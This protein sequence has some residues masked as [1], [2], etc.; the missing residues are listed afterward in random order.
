MAIFTWKGRKVKEFQMIQIL[1]YVAL[2]DISS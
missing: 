1:W 2:F